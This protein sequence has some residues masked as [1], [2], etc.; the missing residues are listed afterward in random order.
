MMVRRS[1]LLI[2]LSLLVDSP[3]LLDDDNLVV[4][5]MRYSILN[6]LRNANRKRAKKAK[7]RID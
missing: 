2:S 6:L 3:S 7:T 5:E 1:I 4:D